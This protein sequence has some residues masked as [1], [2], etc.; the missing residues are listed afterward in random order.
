MSVDG[1]VEELTRWACGM[2]GVFV[3]NCDDRTRTQRSVSHADSLLLPPL[4]MPSH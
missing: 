3:V 1:M 2:G 4:S